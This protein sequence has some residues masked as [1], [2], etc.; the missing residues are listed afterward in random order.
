MEI[1]EKS[2]DLTG[3][4]QRYY[5]DGDLWKGGQRGPEGALGAIGIERQRKEKG[6]KTME[7]GKS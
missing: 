6:W 3:I 2:S 4:F 7:E 5:I 1:L